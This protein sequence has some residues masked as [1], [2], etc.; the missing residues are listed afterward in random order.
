MENTAA[1]ERRAAA[2]VGRRTGD[3]GKGAALAGGRGG[4]GGQQKA[5]NQ[6][7]KIGSIHR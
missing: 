5:S 6:Q 4:A 2:D 3:D 1:I 7:E